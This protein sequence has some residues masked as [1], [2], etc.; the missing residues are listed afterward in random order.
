MSIFK[1]KLNEIHDQLWLYFDLP[2][3]LKLQLC[4]IASDML[5]VWFLWYNIYM[6]FVLMDADDLLFAYV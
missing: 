6:A 3:Q 2:I 1:I 5:Y 4:L